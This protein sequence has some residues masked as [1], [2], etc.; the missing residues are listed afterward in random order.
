MIQ[1]KSV[2][3]GSRATMCSTTKPSGHRA[4]TQQSGELG[5][6]H[7]MN[8]AEGKRVDVFSVANYLVFMPRCLKESMI[9]VILT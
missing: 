7:I 8:L 6:C 3:K 2:Q 5:S 1:K 4:Y 9:I